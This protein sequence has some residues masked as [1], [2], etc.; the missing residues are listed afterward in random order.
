MIE[1]ITFNA[2]SLAQFGQQNIT[3]LTC[4][5]DFDRFLNSTAKDL[6]MKAIICFV[7]YAGLMFALQYL[8]E[9]GYVKIERFVSIHRYINNIYTA[10]A[11]MIL[12]YSLLVM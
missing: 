8:Y 10:I 3:R 5:A 12:L 2:S 1:N 6:N 9:K 4:E 11:I 7:S